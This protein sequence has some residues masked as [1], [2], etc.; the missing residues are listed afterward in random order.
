[1]L[2]PAA[3]ITFWT[4]GGA[5]ESA[6]GGTRYA[7]FVFSDGDTSDVVELSPDERASLER[8]ILSV[9][10]RNARREV[11]FVLTETAEG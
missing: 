7:S 2:K 6:D 11:V 9:M 8:V 5:T 1:M 4:E 10:V 3:S